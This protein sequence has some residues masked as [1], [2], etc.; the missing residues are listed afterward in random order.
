M[1]KPTHT[2]GPWEVNFGMRPPRVW[3]ALAPEAAICDMPRWAI[4][5]WDERSANARL[6]A[7]APDLL[8]ALK[9]FV[10]DARFAII[11]DG[12]AEAAN[13]MLWRARAAIAAAEG[14]E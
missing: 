11:S 12:G 13:E 7:A 2:P 9:A 5:N 3:A 10:N 4:E 8:A 6:I 1:S 14:E